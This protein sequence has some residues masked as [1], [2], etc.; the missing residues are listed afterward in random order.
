MAMLKR[1]L[2]T[3]FVRAKTHERVEAKRQTRLAAEVAVESKQEEE[4]RLAREQKVPYIHTYTPIHL[5]TYTPIHLPIHLYTYTPTH[6]RTDTLS[7][8]RKTRRRP[9]ERGRRRSAKRIYGRAWKTP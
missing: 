2:D 3:K 5:Y 8:R 4:E 7:H 9:V 1:Y 6:L